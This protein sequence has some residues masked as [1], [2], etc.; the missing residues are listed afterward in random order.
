VQASQAQK[1]GYRLAFQVREA[2]DPLSLP[3]GVPADVYQTLR[4]AMKQAA[5]DPGY[6]AAMLQRGFEGGYRT[7]EDMD[8]GLKALQGASPETL[9]VV[10]R[11]YTGKS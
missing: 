10:K 7:P 9:S 11:M 2:F 4:D 1:D 8:Q 3:K 6:K 5:E